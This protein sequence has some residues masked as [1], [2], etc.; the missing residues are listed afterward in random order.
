MARQMGIEAVPGHTFQFTRNW[1]LNRNLNAFREVI[2]PEWAGKPITY[3]ELGVFEGMSMTWMLQRVLT[4]PD[5]RAVG[6]D[7]WLM[8]TK[9]DNVEMDHVRQRAFW[10]TSPWAAGGFLRDMTCQLIRGN[11][12]EVLR[13]MLKNKHGYAGIKR[14]RLD[15]CMVD[16]D[17]N[18]LGV[19]DDCRLV[20][21]LLKP[22]GWMICD[23][24]E[25]D[26]PKAHHVK[27]GLAAFLAETPGAEL[28][29]KKDYIECY[30]KSINYTEC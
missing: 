24:V 14:G 15:L 16:G 5:A 29:V 25:N 27:E 20:W 28:V 18:E 17:H 4:H 11:S 23:D 3:L 30:R 21:Q 1:F 2:L 19:L 26:K 8:T 10:N 7:P 6:V 12:A 13:L 9:I 22:G